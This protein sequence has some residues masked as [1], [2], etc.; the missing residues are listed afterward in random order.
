MCDRSLKVVFILKY[1]IKILE[2][3]ESILKANT[4]KSISRR[5]NVFFHKENDIHPQTVL[6]ISQQAK[7]VEFHLNVGCRSF[8]NFL[9]YP[10]AILIIHE[11]VY[12][13]NYCSINCLGYIEIGKDTLFGEGVKLYDHNHKYHYQEEKLEIEKANFAIGK[14]VIGKNCWIGSNVTILKDVE[15]GDN[16]IIGANCLIHKS[17]ASNSVVKHSEQLIISSNNKPNDFQTRYE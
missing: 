10:N 14:I 13:N 15:I 8:C 2:K 17:I 11:G 7:K 16:V 5:S 1:I 4:R 6:D 12:F 9:V 3:I